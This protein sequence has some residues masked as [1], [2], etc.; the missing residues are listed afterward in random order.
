M[1]IRYSDILAEFVHGDIKFMP[2]HEM[3]ALIQ[4][5]N[6]QSDNLPADFP[7]EQAIRTKV[8]QL[9][10]QRKNESTERD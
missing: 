7:S 2:K 4:V 10:S 3:N 9:R 1:D 8:S 5:F 6:L